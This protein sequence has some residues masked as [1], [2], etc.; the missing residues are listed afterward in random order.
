M[1][2]R[3]NKHLD[4]MN[5]FPF[6]TRRLACERKANQSHIGVIQ[7]TLRQW[8][9]RDPPP[10]VRRSFSEQQSGDL[11]RLRRAEFAAS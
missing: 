1:G 5:Q 8:D 9:K 2:A 6:E 4:F 11:V 3:R 7:N 10:P